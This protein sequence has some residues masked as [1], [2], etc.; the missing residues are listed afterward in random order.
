MFHLACAQREV[1]DL[2]RQPC[3][4]GQ[5]KRRAEDLTDQVRGVRDVQNQLSIA[6]LQTV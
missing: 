4:I 5:A 1:T 6:G 2:D 3:L